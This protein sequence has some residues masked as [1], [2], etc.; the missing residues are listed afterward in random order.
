M[1]PVVFLSIHNIK[2]SENLLPKFGEKSLGVFYFICVFFFL[3]NSVVYSHGSLSARI[4]EISIEI[5][6]NPTKAS[7]YFERG[8]LYFQ[9]FEYK[10]STK[11]YLKAEKLGLR[12]GSLHFRMAETYFQR[13]LYKNALKRLENE[14]LVESL[15]LEATKLK[16]QIF[17]KLN[18][19]LMAYQFYSNYINS[20]TNLKPN[21]IIEYCN[22]ILRID[23]ENYKTAINAIN[24]GL[25]KLG[26]NTITLQ[27]KKLDYLIASNQ[28]D[29]VLNQ[30][31]Y[32]ILN[33][34]RK[35][36]WYYKKAVYLN[37]IQKQQDSNIALQ[38]AK[39]SIALL[40]PK[41]QNTIAI[42]KL[43]HQINELEKNLT[44]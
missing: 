7:L 43:L 26:E 5:S 44:L 39:T 12:D 30:Y 4:N 1:A 41:Y 11:D 16:A 31:N 21:D 9:H 20:T 15:T 28:L 3:F 25:L 10:K 8:F 23:D 22:I 13:K 37:T 32:F 19:P 14:N 34:T 2:L 6:K 35:E 42:K 33:T 36:L 18:K 38:Q 40:S 17:I 27:L 24:T 29:E